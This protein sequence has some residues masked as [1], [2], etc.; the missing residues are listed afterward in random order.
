MSLIAA[1]LCTTVKNTI[2]PISMRSNA[3]KA[4]PNGFMATAVAG[5]ARPRATPATMPIST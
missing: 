3:T 2:G 4:S 1:R 5:A